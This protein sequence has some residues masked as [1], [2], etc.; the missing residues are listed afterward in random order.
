MTIP[1]IS[2]YLGSRSSRL[3]DI[4]QVSIVISMLA[5]CG[6]GGGD[7]GLGANAPEP[8][9]ARCPVD[10][11]AR[12]GTVLTDSGAVTGVN[13]GAL[14]SWKGIPYAAPP[15]GP[16]RWREP[17]PA[18]CWAGERL[19]SEYGAQ[20]PQLADDAVVGDEDCLTLNVWAPEQAEGAPVLF[21]V[22]G[23]GN[24]IG[25]ASDPLY[26]GA[27]LASRTGSVV[28]TI[29]Y[30]LG[31]L[32]F[33]AHEALSQ[34]SAAGVSGN[35]GFL[36][37]VAA[38]EWVQ[39][40]I[41]GFGGDPARVLLFG[42]SAGAQNTLVHMASPR[43]AGLFSSALVQSGGTY[44]TTLAQGIEQMAIVVDTVGCNG[45]DELACM[46]GRS[47]AEIAAVPSAPG[48]LE[49]GLQY[50]PLI[51]GD[52]LPDN[53]AEVI[54]RGEH[55]HVPFVIGSN[56]HET[57]R[58]V[59]S[60]ASEAEYE[61]VVRGMYGLPLGNLLLSQYPASGF[62]SPRAALIRLTTD[63][64]WTCPTRRLARAAAASQDEPVFRYYFSW[65]AP[66]PAGILIGATHGLE[67]PFVFRN[68][69]ALSSGFEPSAADIDLSVTMQRFW[70]QLAAGGN[71]NADDTV[72]W[73]EYQSTGDAYMEFG[74]T[75]V[76]GEGLETGSC[77]FIDSI[78]AG[79]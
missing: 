45:A 18:Q 54:A 28:V 8:V 14:W 50:G 70:S 31:A 20:C 24:T 63:V 60:V 26:D 73:P 25:S 2:R 58:M 40:N 36:D 12:P 30:R 19:A 21:F 34:E 10:V 76:A 35:Y 6:G 11:A 65:T 74:S 43:S 13:E 69:S 56:A 23:G 29:E 61:A 55:N 51:D 62:A 68:F 64:T 78:L 46:R 57:S 39:A 17:E 77:D 47:V 27:E 16:L 9:A 53:A 5:A 49:R 22:H 33:F 4:L 41:A 59:A 79:N 1:D 72:V 75:V 32:G 44:K 37:Q 52:I 7:T 42:E 67:L 38:L 66:G 71:P 3:S 15:L 48:P